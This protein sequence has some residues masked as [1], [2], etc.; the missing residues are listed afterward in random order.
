MHLFG[1]VIDECNFM[2]LGFVGPKYTW[3]KHFDNGVSN[4]ERLDR[5][6]ANN[7]WFLKFLGTKVNHIICIS[8]DHL[9]LF[10][11]LFGLELPVRRKVLRF[12]EM[13]LSDSR[14]GEPI[15]ATWNNV[16][17]PSS[18]NKILKQVAQCEKE[19]TWWNHNI[20]G[21]VRRELVEKKKQLVVAKRAA[22][23]SRN[24]FLI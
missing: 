18:N 11:N 13:W 17:E 24:N 16:E 6:L 1:E 9:P 23:M 5:E 14:C 22:M 21:N 3:S 4:W 12:E 19:L 8:S 20:F 10:F 7:S 2:D 15:E